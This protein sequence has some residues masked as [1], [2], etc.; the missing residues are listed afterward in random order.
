[1]SDFV[2]SNPWGASAAANGL[3]ATVS[4][5]RTPL[6]ATAEERSAAA[7]DV[8]AMHEA[9]AET[10]AAEALEARGAAAGTPAPAPAASPAAAASEAAPPGWEDELRGA[11]GSQYEAHSDTVGKWLNTLPAGM[12]EALEKS[13][14]ASDPGFVVQILHFARQ[15]Q[16]SAWTRDGIEKFIRTNPQV[17]RKSEAIQFAYRAM[18]EADLKKGK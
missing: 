10:E 6:F 3:P 12:R 8:P 7:G 1:M 16:P 13:P 5:T 4:I 18:I 14:R 15:P 2:T 9:M 17:Y 11:W